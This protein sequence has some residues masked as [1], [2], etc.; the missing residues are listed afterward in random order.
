MGSLK[1]EACIKEVIIPWISPCS[2]KNTSM[3]SS[4]FVFMWVPVLTYQAEFTW[5]GWRELKQSSWRGRR[6]TESVSVLSRA[7]RYFI[8]LSETEYNGNHQDQ[9]SCSC[10]DTMML[11]NFTGCTRLTSKINCP[12]KFPCFLEIW[13]N[14]ERNTKWSEPLAAQR[15]VL[16]PQSPQCLRSHGQP[17]MQAS[18][19]G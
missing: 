11:A 16:A 13:G 8:P 9:Y 3:S 5:Y 12:V 10:H 19:G 15:S 17:I 4:K 14:I 6:K 18:Q 1:E 7:P 2:L